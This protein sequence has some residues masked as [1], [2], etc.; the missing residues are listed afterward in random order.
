MAKDP[1]KPAINL[2]SK[3]VNLDTLFHALFISRERSHIKHQEQI[4]PFLTYRL[5]LGAFFSPGVR[6][7]KVPIT[8]W[9][10]K[11]ILR[12][13]GFTLTIQILLLF[14]AKQ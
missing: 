5:W 9:A 8:F 3:G 11:A 14:K 7:S 2:Q 10:R 1:G 12:A 13:Q 4:G 6:F